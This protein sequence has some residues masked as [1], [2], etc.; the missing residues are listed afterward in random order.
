MP[1]QI[2][3]GG[4]PEQC[5]HHGGQPQGDVRF[6]EHCRERPGPQPLAEYR[7]RRRVEVLDALAAI[8]GKRGV[9]I[10]PVVVQGEVLAI[11]GHGHEQQPP[12]EGGHPKRQGKRLDPLAWATAPGRVL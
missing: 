2:E 12:E 10:F 5:Q 9:G 8:E 7:H 1:Q 4:Q 6:A 11:G 3:K